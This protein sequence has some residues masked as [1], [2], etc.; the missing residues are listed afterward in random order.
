M[1]F[2]AGFDSR[3]QAE[4]QRQRVSER[5]RDRDRELVCAGLA[6]VFFIPSLYKDSKTITI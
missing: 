1:V 2:C 3:V 4:R 5:E 6:D